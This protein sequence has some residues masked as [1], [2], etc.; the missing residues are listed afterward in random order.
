ATQMSDFGELNLGQ[1]VRE[2]YGSDALLIGFSTYAGEVTAAAEWGGPAN[3]MTV[4]P[5]LPG[6]YEELFHSVN[7]PNYLLTLDRTHKE[8]LQVPRLE[9]AIGVIYSPLTERQSHYFYATLTDQFDAIIHI[10]E[11]QAV[12]PIE[13]SVTWQT[14]EAAETYPYGV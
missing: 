4:P 8:G 1:L 10:D 7:L 13:K 3:R 14:G 11:T 2:D 9:R 12:E 6:S 5:A